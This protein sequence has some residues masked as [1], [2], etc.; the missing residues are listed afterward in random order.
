[1]NDKQKIDEA[2]EQVRCAMCNL[3]N[4]GNVF[5]LWKEHPFFKVVKLQLETAE[6]I[7]RGQEEVL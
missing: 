1:M 4:L 3:D 7:L 2:L 5:S 6:R